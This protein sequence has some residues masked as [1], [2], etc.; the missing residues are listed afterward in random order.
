MAK[1]PL[2]TPVGHGSAT[3]TRNRPPPTSGDNRL[4]AILP[5]A[6]RNRIVST[7]ELVP[8]TLKTLVQPP[9]QPVRFVYFPAGGFISVVTVLQDG[10]MVETATV[11]REGAVGVTGALE[12]A[13]ADGAAMVQGESDAC[14]RMTAAAYRDE[15]ER[16]G[17]FYAVMT[18]YTHAFLAF[19]MQSTACNAVHSVEQRLARWLLMAQDRIEANEFPLTQ[20][21]V[22]MMRGT[23]RQR[24]AIVAGILQTAGLITYRRGVVTV[25]NREN[26]EAR[27]A[28]ATRRPVN[29][30]RTVTPDGDTGSR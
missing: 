8:L 25:R 13:P 15:M 21:F 20:E 19:V 29:C 17:P 27:H 28:S 1:H 7:F 26:L 23:S 16:R 22:A 24:V 10:T 5:P 2:P 6:D 12:D 30:S 14:Y 3:P 4:L 11:G 9:G 18:R